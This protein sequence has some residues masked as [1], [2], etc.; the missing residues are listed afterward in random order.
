MPLGSCIHSYI[1]KGAWIIDPLL[2]PILDYCNYKLF[3]GHLQLHRQNM[4]SEFDI[5]RSGA[6]AV[7]SVDIIMTNLQSKDTDRDRS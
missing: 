2:R 5:V 3:R 1:D 6:V 7:L 4:T